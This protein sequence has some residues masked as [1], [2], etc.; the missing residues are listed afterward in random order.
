MTDTRDRLAEAAISHV[1]FDGMNAA[2]LRAGAKDLGLSEDVAK[3]F[4]PAGG[5]DLAAWIHRKGDRE[6]AEWMSGQETGQ[7][8]ISARIA[9]AIARR[10]ELADVE[11]V[12][13]ASAILALPANQPLAARLVWET[14]DTIWTGLNDSSRDVNWYSKRATL[15]AVYSASV[16]YWLGD[17]SAGHA[18]TRGFID[19]RIEGVMQFEKL[20]ARARKLPGVTM[21]TDL[22]TGWI[23]APKSTEEGSRP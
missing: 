18:D 15:A 7:G 1:P 4:F 3:A 8:G 21:L 10:L 20:K 5:A 16:L 6:L 12:R 22:A 23:R 14:A 19:R 9:A 17:S 2:A 11:L 13:A